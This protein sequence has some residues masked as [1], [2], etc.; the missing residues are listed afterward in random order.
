MTSLP[1]DV[2]LPTTVPVPLHRHCLGPGISCA[3]F[4]SIFILAR[5][6]LP[7][8]RPDR[9]AHCADVDGQWQFQ[10]AEWHR[11]WGRR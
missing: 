10:W 11:Q 4:R 8:P 6:V 2:D 3:K 7:Q 5:S 1:L 9:A